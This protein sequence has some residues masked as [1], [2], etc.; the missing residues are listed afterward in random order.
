M[1]W[2]VVATALPL[3]LRGLWVSL[4][5]AGISI[6]LSFP[7]GCLI[8]IGRLSHRRWLNFLCASFVNILRCN[9]LILIL[10]WFYFLVPIIIGHVVN[11][12]ASIIIAFVIFFSAYFAEIVRSGIQSIGVR[13]I[14]AGLSSGLTYVQTLRFIVMPQ[15]VRAMLPALTTQCIVVFQGTTVAYV[16][17][18]DELLHTAAMA[19]ERTVRPVELYLAVAAMYFSV[20]YCGSLLARRFE[21]RAGA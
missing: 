17:G 16:I 14:Q 21:K 12:F 15:A 7:L 18:F 1:D 5:L 13:Q 2:S 8:A 9:P 19:A 11:D 3:L 10:F 6:L 20:C 4:E